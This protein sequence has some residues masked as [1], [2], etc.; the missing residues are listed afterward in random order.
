MTN[1][2]IMLSKIAQRAF[3]ETINPCAKNAFYDIRVLRDGIA[4]EAK[5]DKMMNYRRITAWQEI[6]ANPEVLNYA[7]DL[8]KN[9][10][11]HHKP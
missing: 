3:D 10:V 2:T 6:D 9:I 8:V 4:I 11:A 7:F 5:W 1:L